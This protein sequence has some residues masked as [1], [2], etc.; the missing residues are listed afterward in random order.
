[1]AGEWL[2]SGIGS[3]PGGVT[4]GWDHVRELVLFENS[5]YRLIPWNCFFV[6]FKFLEFYFHFVPKIYYFEVFEFSQGV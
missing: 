1:M 5:T 2:V 4:S 6:S 3:R